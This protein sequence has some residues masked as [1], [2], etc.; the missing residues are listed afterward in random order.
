M[1]TTEKELPPVTIGTLKMRGRGTRYKTGRVNW[2]F[3][4]SRHLFPGQASSEKIENYK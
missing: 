4:S 2:G 1:K 3:L